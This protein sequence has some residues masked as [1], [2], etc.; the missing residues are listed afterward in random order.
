MP[1]KMLVAGV[2]NTFFS[3]DGFGVEVAQR[4]EAE[5]HPDWVR[6][7][8]FGIR[9]LHLVYELLEGAYDTTVLV[10]TTPR[11]GAPG[12]VYLIEPESD[13]APASPDPHGMSLEAVLT[14]LRSLGG[15]P[16]RVL[17]VGCEPASTGEGIGLSKPVKRAIGEAVRLV[18]ELIEREA[19]E[20][21][22]HAGGSGS[23]G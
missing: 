22:R 16:G 19:G 17:I 13:T 1:G 10:D 23:G 6:V 12:T 7:I 5:P 3:D 2:G 11:G 21:V 4:L 20:A 18:R 9:G 14:S 15:D 8:D